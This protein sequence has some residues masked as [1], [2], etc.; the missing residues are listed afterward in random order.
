MT[1]KVFRSRWIF[2]ISQPPIED[3]WVLAEGHRILE[4]GDGKP[5]AGDFAVDDLGES[6]ILPGLVNAHTHLE[7]S[8]LTRPLGRPGI[9]LPEWVGLVL[10][11][12]RQ[13]RRDPGKT[14]AAGLQQCEAAGVRLVGEIATTPWAG[15]RHPHTTEIVAFAEVLG[16][17]DQRADEKVAAAAAHLAKAAVSTHVSGGVSPHAPYSTSLA[18]VER[19]VRLASQQGAVVAMH[20]AESEDERELIQHGGG[21]FAEVLQQMGLLPP[22]MF[23]LGPDATLQFLKLLA[24]APGAL[25][26]H[27]NDL[28]EPEIDWLAQQPQLSVVY[29]PRTH[30]FFGYPPHPVKR[31]LQRDIR[32][33]LGT[34]SR[35]SNPDLS[36]WNE[37]LWLFEHRSDLDRQDVLAMATLQGAD[38]LQRPD[39]GRIAPEANSGLVQL[40]GRAD[41]LEGLVARWLAGGEPRFLTA[42]A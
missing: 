15:F 26:V 14:I 25:I 29:C 11:E 36:L 8:S 6:T 30:A 9:A 42:D 12:R 1:A 31:L 2:P 40:D 3:G 28:R 38:A 23:P 32:V 33:A 18:T 20:L 41:D 35:A 16:L 7:F 10:A 27:G 22:G 39:L 13:S 34:D 17:A 37:V 21:P 19:A 4:L 5:P 24:Q